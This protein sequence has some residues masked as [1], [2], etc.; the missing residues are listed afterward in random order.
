[1]FSI[2]FLLG[3]RASFDGPGAARAGPR[4]SFIMGMK[5]RSRKEND[6]NVIMGSQDTLV[7]TTL[8]SRIAT[9]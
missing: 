1:M 7:D 2:A 9:L 8:S 6:G 5:A 4:A 3:V